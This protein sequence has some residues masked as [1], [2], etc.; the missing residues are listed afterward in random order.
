MKPPIVDYRNLNRANLF[1]PEYR[2]LT[3]LWGWAA[4]LALYC[5]TE[6]MIPAER[7]AIVHIWLDDRIPF[8]EEFVIPYVFWY[9][10]ITFSL[11][12]FLLYDPG[13]F[14]NLQLRIMLVQAAATII[15]IL[16][17]T[18]QELRPEVFPRDNGFTEIVKL[19]YSLDTNTG[20]CPS[21]HVAVSLC[22]GVVW[23]RQRGVSLLWK[24]CIWF[25]V[26]LICLST[27]FIKQHSL[28]DAFAAVGIFLPVD[29]ALR[30]YHKKKR[31]EAF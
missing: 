20:V 1:S 8:R 24:V 4:Y 26:G 17:P 5:L 27:L 28:W 6:S 22:I 25:A 7:C 21:L 9:G 13:S 14:Q 12:Y 31:S 15:Y 29:L 11:F 30:L 23:M 18:R 2:H 3:L 16:F 10:L 19:L